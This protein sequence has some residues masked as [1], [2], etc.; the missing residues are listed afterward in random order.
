MSIS[1][2]YTPPQPTSSTFSKS[3]ENT[4]T[5]PVHPPLILPHSLLN[6]ILTNLSSLP[7]GRRRRIRWHRHQGTI[8][9]EESQVPTGIA[10]LWRPAGRLCDEAL[11]KGSVS[12]SRARGVVVP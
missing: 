11:R 5:N 7:L 6:F 8:F 9:S 12:A 1:F 2:K 4:K 10:R 3:K